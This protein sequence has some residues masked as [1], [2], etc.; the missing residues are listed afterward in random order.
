MRFNLHSV[1]ASCPGRAESAS[2]TGRPALS[3]DRKRL[4]VR[5]PSET[6]RLLGPHCRRE[7]AGRPGETPMC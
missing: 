4:L 5:E 1:R 7:G 6:L 2:V 3:P